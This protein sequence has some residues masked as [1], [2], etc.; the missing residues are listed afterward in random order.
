MDLDTQRYDS[1]SF[2]KMKH[3]IN[4]T[5]KDKQGILLSA[6][7]MFHVDLQLPIKINV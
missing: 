5:L 3:K 1:H 4:S 7:P 2:A 6:L